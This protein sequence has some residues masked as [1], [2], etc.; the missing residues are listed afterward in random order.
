MIF[1][2]P[3]PAMLNDLLGEFIVMV[4]SWSIVAI[5]VK[6]YPGIS[7]SQWISGVAEEKYLCHGV[8]G[9]LFQVFEIDVPGGL[10]T[11]GVIDKG[12]GCKF[13]KVVAYRGEETIVGRSLDNDLRKMTFGVPAVLRLFDYVSFRTDFVQRQ[14][15]YDDRHGCT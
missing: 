7:N 11:L 6:W 15:L 5:G 2:I 3:N 4:L 12:I 14:S 8:G 9:L 13:T 10:V 1:D